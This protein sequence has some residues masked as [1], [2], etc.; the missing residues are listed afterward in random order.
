MDLALL[1]QSI[2]TGILLGGLYAIVGVGLS[3]IFGIM[4]LTNIAHGNLM[5]LC[6]FLIMVFA[7]VFSNNILLALIFTRGRSPPCW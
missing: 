7:S 3:L 2:V 5:I 4:G 6:S 1:T